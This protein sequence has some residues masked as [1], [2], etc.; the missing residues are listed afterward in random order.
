MDKETSIEQVRKRYALASGGLDE[1]GRRA[2]AASEALTLGWGG[3]TVV[4]QATGLARATIGL[5]IKEVRGA[6]ASAEAGRVRRPGG[7]RKHLVVKDPL[8]LRDLEGLVEPTARGDPE[9]PLRWTSKS[10]RKLACALG[11]LGHR[12]SHQWVATALAQLGYSLQG[13]RKTREG[14]DHPDRDAQFAQIS[15]TSQ[16]YLAAGDPVIS[17]DAKKKELVGDFKNGGREWR[18]KGQPEEV[19][20][21]DFK[22]PAWGRVTPYGVYDL[23]ANAG[24]VSVGIDHDTA[25]FAVASI[26]RWWE[27]AGRAR[28]PGSQRLLITADGGGSNGSRTR[29]W[30]W[31][32]QQLADQTGVAITVCH[33]PPG[34]SKWNKIEHRLFSF[35]TQNWR[36]VPL[37]TY[38]VILSLIA[39]TTT[40][41]GLT[42]ES[43]LDPAVY[44]AGIKVTDEELA[45]LHL[46]RDSFHG[47][48]N[49]TIRPR[50]A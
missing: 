38:A 16:T 44:P 30:K 15:Q 6:V 33:F 10:V 39:A 26:R 47:E 31:E 3:V 21:Y 49:Y 4:A 24:W 19:R 9:A 1:R 45:T 40:T 32:L 7:G 28:Y 17:V 37:V 14:G 41:T 25:A 23:A 20:V 13:N 18:P 8:V 36:G 43:Y 2:L 34:T 29:L 27:Q 12:V 35:I 46:D 50:D 42:V 48:W 5:G 22:L 11:A